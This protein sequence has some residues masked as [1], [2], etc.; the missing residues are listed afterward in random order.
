MNMEVNRNTITD[1]IH[2]KLFKNSSVFAMWL[3]GST[4]TN[5][6]DEYSDIDIWVDVKDGSESKVLNE[7]KKIITPFGPV[8]FEFEQ[9]H[10][11][12]K[13]RQKFFHL[14]NTSEFLI[15]DIGIQSHS[16]KFQFEEGDTVKIIF[17]KSKAITFR[18]SNKKQVRM[19]LEKKEAVLRKTFPFFQAWVKKEILRGNFLEAL[20]A[21]HTK[22]LEP[23]VELLRIQHTPKKSDYGLK[24][25]SRDLPKKI[26][27][28]LEDL[29]T[30]NSL[31]E[32]SLK[33]KKANRLFLDTL[34]EMD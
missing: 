29:H 30:V 12:P 17:D 25:I 11:H 6:V 1:A 7:I 8:D 33:L 19:N 34:K 3:E 16:R 5:T 18:K 15:I 32:L 13:I 24:H 22:V 2:K 27:L 14:K 23:L 4:G 28:M 21:Y 20:S 10:P 26:V 9:D 31:Q